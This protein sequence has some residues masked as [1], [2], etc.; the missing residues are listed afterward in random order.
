MAER[1]INNKQGSISTNLQSMKKLIHSKC[2]VINWT[3]VFAVVIF[4]YGFVMTNPSI[5][6]DDENFDFYFKNNGI[7]AS[8]RWG[9]WVIRKVLDSY[10][11]LPVWRD[12]L[13]VII[14][15][16]AALLFI[17]ISEYIS[18]KK[19]DTVIATT[20]LSL[21]LSYPII[22]KMFIYIDNSVETAMCI[23][24]AVIAGGLLISISGDNKQKRFVC[25]FF[26][27][28]FLVLGCAIIENTL[29]VRNI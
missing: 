17:C 10:E 18:Y 13:A 15:I 19:F 24:F 23:L 9:T 27:L 25:Y 16:V 26:C 1:Y 29:L 4:S 14:L 5:G 3:I 2:K 21:F 28:T 12:F 20:T 11:Y 6:I 7:V 22:A 8:G